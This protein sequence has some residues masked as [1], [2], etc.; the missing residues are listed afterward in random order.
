[1]DRFAKGIRL[2]DGRLLLVG[3]HADILQQLR[4][5]PHGGGQLTGL[6]A[7]VGED[8]EKLQRS[9]LAVAGGHV[10]EEDDMA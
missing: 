6:F 8:A 7:A 5:L 1:M 9:Q 10:I 2:H 3:G 4:V